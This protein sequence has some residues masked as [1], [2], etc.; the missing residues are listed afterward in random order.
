[1]KKIS[2]LSPIR[3]TNDQQFQK[4]VN[5]INKYYSIIDADRVEHIIK[6]DSPLQFKKKVSDFLLSNNKNCKIIHAP[7]T[8]L[9]RAFELLINE[10]RTEYLTFV[11][12]DVIP[13]TGKDFITPCITAMDND[14]DLLQICIGG[15][16]ISSVAS[17]TSY[18]SVID[19]DLFLNNQIKLDH[20]IIV[21][22]TIWKTRNDVITLSKIMYIMAFWNQV[23]RTPESKKFVKIIRSKYDPQNP[24]ADLFCAHCYEGGRWNTAIGWADGMEWL[25]DY[26]IGFLNFC[27][28]IY[29]NG[30][31][32]KRIDVFEK[33]HCNEITFSNYK[34][35]VK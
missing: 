3:I 8:I 25:G 35:R 22:D 31:I 12:D 26:K 9:S 15:T 6:D 11:F 7:Y 23:M 17:N 4:F 32:N 16:F 28:Y 18:L 10:C 33:E 20:E 19:G 29:P 1:M 5:V 2:F 14:K 13:V 21:E 24:S 27:P 30:R 34:E